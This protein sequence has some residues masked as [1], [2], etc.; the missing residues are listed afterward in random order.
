[1][2]PAG[3]AQ[4]FDDWCITAVS[5]I[6]EH[7]GTDTAL[8][9]IVRLSSRALRVSQSERGVRLYIVGDSGRRYEPAPEPNVVPLTVSLAPHDS[10]T[11]SRL[12]HVPT[13]VHNPLLVVAH[14]P[15]PG[16]CIIGD[17]QSFLHKPT[18]MRLQ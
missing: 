18:V 14:G 8:R 9:V 2:V 12:F 17:Q 1:V 5:A 4:C 10:L 11:T 16:C 15:F 3:E 6:R 13:A 7:A